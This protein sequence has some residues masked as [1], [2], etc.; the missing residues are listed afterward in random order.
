MSKISDYQTK[1]KS[2]PD[3]DNYLLAESNLPGPRGNLELAEAVASQ[4]SREQF[5]NWLEW[6][7]LQTDG[8]QG[9]IWSKGLLWLACVSHAC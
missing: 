2:L 5:L 8:K 4:G 3:W 7:K 1:L 6:T 9:I